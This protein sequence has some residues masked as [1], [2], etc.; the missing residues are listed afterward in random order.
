MSTSVPPAFH[1]SINNTHSRPARHLYVCTHNA[2]DC[3]CGTIGLEIFKTLSALCALPTSSAP[4]SA[5]RVQEIGHIGGHNYA[6]NILD[7][8][9]GDLYGGI[10]PSNVEAFTGALLASATPFGADAGPT[11]RSKA[12]TKLLSGFWRGRLGMSSM[13]Q[14]S[15]HTNL[16]ERLESRP[17]L[18]EPSGAGHMVL[19]D[20]PSLVSL[21]FE[22]HDGERIRIDAE[23]GNSV[24]EVAKQRGVPSIEGTCGGK[25]EVWTGTLIC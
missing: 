4:S 22:T 24:M 8:P 17:Q 16:V 23:E 2:R 12:D 10:W 13:E 15:F 21:V 3:R 1:I 9:N 14:E 20:K 7:F 6:A 18:S 25:L 19:G 5:L 11:S